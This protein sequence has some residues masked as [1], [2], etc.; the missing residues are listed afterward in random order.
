MVEFYFLF[1]LLSSEKNEPFGLPFLLTPP[2]LRAT[3]PIFCG[4]KHPV[5]LRD[6]A[7]E[8][9]ES[10][11]PLIAERYSA[12]GARQGRSL[13]VALY[14]FAIFLIQPPRPLGTPPIFPYGNTGGEE[15]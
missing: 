15:G 10:N 7:G 9:G 14:S 13:E 2:S 8:E 12:Y 5:R 3:S 6:T 4:A 1:I 11:P